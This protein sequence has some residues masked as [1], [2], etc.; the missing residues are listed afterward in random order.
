[1]GRLPH[2]THTRN[3]LAH[4]WRA[5]HSELSRLTQPVPGD[6]TFIQRIISR[7]VTHRTETR[8]RALLRERSFLEREL[9]HWS[10]GADPHEWGVLSGGETDH[11]DAGTGLFL[12]EHSLSQ[13]SSASQEIATRSQ[14]ILDSLPNLRAEAELGNINA[15]PEFE[16]QL[17]AL[18]ETLGLSDPH[19][20]RFLDHLPARRRPIPD[21]LKSLERQQYPVTLWISLKGSAS[22]YYAGEPHIELLD[23][24]IDPNLRGKGLGTATLTEL[25]NY[26]DHQRLPIEGRLE[27]GPRKPDESVPPLARWYAR[28]GFTQGDR[29]PHQWRRRATIRREPQ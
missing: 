4:E 1:M 16:S 5:L 22:D 9:R 23:I 3:D 10:V 17:I 25:C 26:A 6:R 19:R 12:L 24:V 13:L 11:P 2:T 29:A 21:V 28:H 27:P 8:I 18:V 20:R 7:L 14:R 15:V